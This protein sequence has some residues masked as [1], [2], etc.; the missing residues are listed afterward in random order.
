M[1]FMFEM[2]LRG[3]QGKPVEREKLPRRRV[4][5]DGAWCCCPSREGS[6]LGVFCL[7]RIFEDFWAW[8]CGA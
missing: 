6:A 8:N 7:C 2:G 3:V 1:R 5:K 4:S